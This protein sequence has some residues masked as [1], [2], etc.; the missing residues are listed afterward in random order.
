MGMSQSSAPPRPERLSVG[1]STRVEYRLGRAPAGPSESARVSSSGRARGP[2][3]VDQRN[4]ASGRR[5]RLR[6]TWPATQFVMQMRFQ[7]GVE[8]TSALGHTSRDVPAFERWRLL[9]DP[10]RPRS[11]LCRK[12]GLPIQPASRLRCSAASLGKC[13]GRCW[14]MHR[15]ADRGCSAR[16]RVRSHFRQLGRVR[17]VLPSRIPSPHFW[18]SR[19]G[20]KSAVRADDLTTEH[21]WAVWAERPTRGTWLVAGGPNQ[22]PRGPGGAR[23]RLGPRAGQCCAGRLAD[24]HVLFCLPLYIFRKAKLRRRQPAFSFFWAAY[25]K[26]V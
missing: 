19:R 5:P 9:A 17:G 16:A 14:M 24:S 26:G 1:R 7:L 20:A 11:S 25:K 18:R 12:R 3:K 15:R 6:P 4:P 13:A 21:V 23:S 8:W 22:R 10:R 2:T